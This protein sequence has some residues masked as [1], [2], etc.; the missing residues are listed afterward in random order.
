MSKIRDIA[1]FLGTTENDNTDNASLFVG[2]GGGV[3]SY[4]TLDALPV[5][6]LT[7][8]D[9]AF[10]G[11]NR[12]LYVSD[13]NGWYNAA[14]VNR[15]PRWDSGGEPE[16]SYDIVDSATP[17]VINAR[18]IDSDNVNF[19]N[20]SSVTDSAQYMVDITVDS[21]V[22]TFTPKSADSIGIEVA[23][24]NLTDSNGD[25]TYTFK[26]SDGISFVSKAVTIGYSVT[27][28]GG[29]Y[30]TEATRVLNHQV[31]GLDGIQYI[32]IDT[33]GSATTFG[34]NA[35]S[36]YDKAASGDG[37]RG[38]ISGLNGIDYVT[39]STPSDTSDFGDYT[40]G[41]NYMM[42]EGDGT[43]C[44]FFGGNNQTS[45]I[46]YVVVQT[47]GNA[48]GRGSM[49][50]RR[51]N[52]GSVYGGGRIVQGG[53]WSVAD[54]NYVSNE[55]TRE[56]QYFQTGTSGN[57]LDFG[58]LNTTTLYLNGGASDGERGVFCGGM[59]GVAG[60]A[61]SFDISEMQ[62][63]TIQTPSNAQDF[64]DMV[65]AGSGT[66]AASNSTY[67]LVSYR[68]NTIWSIDKFSIA[69]LGNATSFGTTS[70]DGN[71]THN[72]GS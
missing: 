58:D 24:G 50:W 33:G 49:F 10:V 65:A 3:T 38:V 20:Q 6:N 17:L 51:R 5:T 18:A 72:A 46:E 44:Y 43:R 67:G 15:G 8:G 9:T 64:G 37:S 12:R 63:F 48:V 14:L 36:S 13:G 59:S 56:L 7:A 71:K 40:S 53:G 32:Q 31:D 11:E 30:L 27:G 47:L 25:F 22:F 45:P 39:I 68:R 61:T 21:S 66:G 28:G 54:T 69:T 16:A 62:Y 1:A 2:G 41:W 35:S 55:A 70:D 26:W 52:G 4:D 42:N 19:I 23:A 57:A 34:T 29:Y 60:Q